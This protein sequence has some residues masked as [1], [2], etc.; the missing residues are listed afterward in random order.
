[1]DGYGYPHLPLTRYYDETQQM[2]S[3]GTAR[4]YLNALLPY[5]SY[6]ALDEWRQRRGDQWTS[7]PE[8]VQ[9]SVRDYLVHKLQCKVQRRDTYELVRLTAQSPST[10]HIFLSAL[11]LFYHMARRVAWYP[12]AHPLIDPASYLLHEVDMVGFAV[13]RTRAPMPQASGVEQP[14]LRRPS[15]SYFRLVGEEWTPHPI[16]DPELPKRL[17]ASFKAAKLD[18]RDQIVVRM[19]YESGARIREILQ[20]TIGDWRARGCN[21][22]AKACS[23]GSR[24]RRTKVIR[25]GSETARMLREYI[26]T[27]RR[28]LDPYHRRLEQLHDSD[29]LYLSMRRKPYDYAAFVPHWKKL[30]AITQIDLNIHGL[31]HW[32]VTMAIRVII[33]TSESELE[34][35]RRKE[36][37]VRYMAWRSPE[38][39]QAYE[40]YFK[41]HNHYKVQDQLLTNIYQRELDY[42]KVQSVPPTQTEQQT[43]SVMQDC[44]TATA[45]EE[46]QVDGWANLLALGRR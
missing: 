23:K 10:T 7:E 17:C 37:L 30:C 4:T 35:T 1:M 33:E 32:Y 3:H 6:L 39:L 5:F 9:E 14:K 43:S 46:Q 8:A 45:T 20:L 42:I 11:K 28:I 38:T 40:H 16:D 34:I 29:P 27:D 25:F 2:L 36:E 31:R 26:N 18:L 15:D 22:E 12:H 44:R 13:H 21:Q 19:A 24:G 41:V